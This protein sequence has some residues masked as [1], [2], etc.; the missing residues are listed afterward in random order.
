MIGTIHC[1][2]S[3]GA[4]PMYDV[5]F[6]HM[7]QSLYSFGHNT[8][9]CAVEKEDKTH[10]RKPLFIYFHPEPLSTPITKD[11]KSMAT[12]C[13]FPLRS[14][15]GGLRCS[16]DFEGW[17]HVRRKSLYHFSRSYGGCRALPVCLQ[18]AKRI[19]PTM[20]LPPL[21][22]VGSR[23]RLEMTRPSTK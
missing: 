18:L 22:W 1:Y 7:A 6:I 23:N 10:A 12:C 19:S 3:G 14:Q 20:V 5:V 2:D 16:D 4:T 9:Q 21:C 15:R 17:Y 8:R 11:I 13:H